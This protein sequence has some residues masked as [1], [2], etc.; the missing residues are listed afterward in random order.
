MKEKKEKQNQINIFSSNKS[1]IS[2]KTISHLKRLQKILIIIIF[3][4]YDKVCKY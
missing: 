2:Q 4:L 1:K 3:N